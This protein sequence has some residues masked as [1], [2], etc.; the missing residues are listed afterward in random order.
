MSRKITRRQALG[1]IAAGVMGPAAWG[2]CAKSRPSPHDAQSAPSDVQSSPYDAPP[3]RPPNMVFILADDQA[4]KAVGAMGAFPFL[5]TPGMGR[6]AAEGATF[7][8]TFVTT[9]LCSPSRASIL[10]GCYAHTH[11]VQANDANDPKPEVAQFPAL[12]QKAGYRTA[13][14]GKWHMASGGDHAAPRP[15]FDRWFVMPGQGDYNDPWFNDDGTLAQV[16]GYMT[17]ILTERAIQW[18]TENRDS[19]FCLILAHKAVHDPRLPAPGHESALSDAE[20]PE[21]ASFQDDFFGKPA[22]LRREVLYG[23]DA[24]A[25]QSSQGRAIPDRLPPGTWDGKDS[26]RLDYFR[27][28]LGLDDSIL[29]VLET[30]ENLGI[31][32]QTC[33]AHMSDNGYFLGEHRCGDKRLAYEES[34]RVPLLVRYPEVFAPGSTPAGMALNIDIAPTLL[35]IAGLAKPASMQGESLLPLGAGTPATWRKSFLYEY[36]MEGWLPGI[37]SMQGVR[38][39]TAKLIRYPDVVGDTDELYDLATD[40]LELTNRIGDSAYA[41]TVSELDAELSRLRDT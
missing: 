2:A 40:P 30:L 18:I 1:G 16:P 29:R 28:L 26:Y 11:G 35:G 7:T 31:L 8:N 4:A 12:L 36:W 14:I 23:G 41:E 13:Y 38:T 9:S 17:D 10:T 25:W 20:V 27:C 22:W 21:P 15:G 5:R 34:L 24:S 19:P 39:E 33:V 3:K 6:L 37:P 32:D